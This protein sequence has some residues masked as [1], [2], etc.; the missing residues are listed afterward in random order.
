M[1]ESN[2]DACS[3]LL[4]HFSVL[5]FAHYHLEFEIRIIGSP[6]NLAR[7]LVRMVCAKNGH[8]ES[9]FERSYIFFLKIFRMANKMS[10]ISEKIIAILMCKFVFHLHFFKGSAII[11][12]RQGRSHRSR[13]GHSTM[14]NGGIG[15]CFLRSDAKSAHC[16]YLFACCLLCLT[17]DRPD[18]APTSTLH[19]ALF[20]A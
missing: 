19:W 8:D 9:C 20:I 5:L 3:L 17:W 14:L 16:F 2:W 6:F 15:Q 1:I 12:N 7:S 4:S 10:K 13:S 18:N 11:S